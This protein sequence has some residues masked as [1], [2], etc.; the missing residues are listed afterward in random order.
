MARI[1]TYQEDR[2]I[3]ESDHVIGTD[4]NSK[5]AYRI[6][7]LG[8]LGNWFHDEFG[9]LTAADLPE[10]ASQDRPVSYTFTTG[11]DVQDGSSL[12][13]GFLFGDDIGPIVLAN[14]AEI[15]A[16]IA[17]GTEPPRPEF[18]GGIPEYYFGS[19]EQQPD[20][21]FIELIPPYLPIISIQH[22][23]DSETVRVEVLLTEDQELPKEYINYDFPGYTVVDSNNVM[24][25]LGPIARYEGYI[26]ITT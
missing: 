17:A 14:Q 8:D 23:L 25:N 3:T 4:G 10:G 9:L 11:T 24:V 6:F 13:T 12:M 5:N 20:G 26:K 19:S 2:I 18:T 21:S 22:D 7:R 16:A 1:S 15:D